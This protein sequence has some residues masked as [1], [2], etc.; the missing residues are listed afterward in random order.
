MKFH[1]PPSYFA[2]ETVNKVTGIIKDANNVAKYVVEGSCTEKVEYSTVLNPQKISSFDE[3]KNLNLS[4]P[5]L[6]WK[7]VI[8]P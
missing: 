7:R 3:L 4:Q 5:R 8:P 1:P 6:M 2:K